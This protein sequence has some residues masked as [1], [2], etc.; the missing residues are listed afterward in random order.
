MA[1]NAFLDEVY[2]TSAGSEDLEKVAQANMLAKLAEEEGIDLSGLNEEQLGALA[3]Q[4]ISDQTAEPAAAADAGAEDEAE[5]V[6]QAKF[7]EADF[8]GRT[9]AHAFAQ[10]MAEINKTAMEHEKKEEE[11]DEDDDDKKDKKK[12]PPFVAKEAEQGPL[13]R[14]IQAL[15]GSV[16]S[17]EAPAEA[18]PAQPT[19]EQVKQA[20][21]VMAAAGWQFE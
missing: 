9:M 17:G 13:V 11:D 12:A 4:V 3:E 7:A 21:A 1:M 10:E 18:A 8:L 14:A 6:A 16:D 2:G 19:E 20:M 5:K 15:G